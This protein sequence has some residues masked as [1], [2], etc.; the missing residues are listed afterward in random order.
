MIL[1]SHVAG[2]SHEASATCFGSRPTIDSRILDRPDLC[3]RIPLGW[4]SN[5]NKIQKLINTY[6]PLQNYI[7]SDY[8]SRGFWTA[9]NYF[10]ELLLI[11]FLLQ[12]KFRQAFRVVLPSLYAFP[13]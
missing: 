13:V 11:R 6:E 3:P 1:R 12:C 5:S 10:C 9:S 4:V 8:S 7:L 2:L